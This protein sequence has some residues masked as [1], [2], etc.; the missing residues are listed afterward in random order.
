MRDKINIKQG[1]AAIWLSKRSN[2][3]PWPGIRFEKS[4]ISTTL[5]SIL[6]NA[7]PKTEKIATINKIIKTKGA[8]KLNK[9]PEII[10]IKKGVIIN[11]DKNPSRVLFGLTFFMKALLP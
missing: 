4:F 5:L 1:K 9:S 3:P 6:A 8:D 10:N 7:S 11:A 2:I